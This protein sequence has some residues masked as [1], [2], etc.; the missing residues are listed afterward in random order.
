MSA[1]G[2]L[3]FAAVLLAAAAIRELGAAT[4]S[5]AAGAGRRGRERAAANGTAPGTRLTGWMS[6]LP[7]LGRDASA[8]RLARAGAPDSFGPEGLAMTRLVA[9]TAGTVLAAAATTV[10]PA[11]L[12]IPL[13]MAGFGLGLAAPDLLL[14]R[15]ASRRRREILTLLPDTIDILAVAAAGG[16]G[17]RAALAD[18]ARGGSN[19]LAAELALAVVELESGS[20]ANEAL[21]GLRRRLAGPELA[22]LTLV[23][24]RSARL[25]SPLAEELHRQAASLRDSRRRRLAERAARAA[26]KI[27]LV[28][29]LVLVPS[30][31]LLIAA[32]LA[33]NADRFFSGL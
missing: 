2:L 8:S 29:A 21:R 1:G 33:A 15:V 20:T 4:G 3:V 23:I 12:L 13:L 19:P 7:L 26:P 18:L 30:V 17:T 32:G 9:A 22:A 16:R 5:A 25:G 24:E 6:E 28:I 31:L 11:R 10:L 27:Q 14:E